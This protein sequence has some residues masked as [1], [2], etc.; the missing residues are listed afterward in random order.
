[1][2][3]VASRIAAVTLALA[4]APRAARAEVV[5]LEE[6]EA[7]AVQNRASVASAGARVAG[8]EARIALAKVPYY[9]TVDLKTSAILAPGGRVIH[10]QDY[11][12]TQGA[13]YSSAQPYAVF[14][15]RPLG[16]KGAW[17]PNFHYDATVS[18]ASRLYDF[19]RTAASVS[20]ARADREATLA[21]VRSERTAVVLEVRAAYL[22][23]LSAHGTRA[24]LAQTASDAAALRAHTEANI[25]EGSR[26]GAELAAARFEEA[27]AA[28]DLERSESDLDTARLDLEQATGAPLASNAEPDESLLE[29]EPPPTSAPATADVAFLE[30]RRDAFAASAKAHGHPYVPVLGLG[31]DAGLRGQGATPFPVY[32]LGLTLSVPIFDGGL[33]SANA[34]LATAQ[35]NDFAAQA[36]EAQNKSQVQAQ[37]SRSLLE[38]SGRRVELA[39]ALVAAADEQVKHAEDQ[40]ALGSATFDTVVQARMQAEHAR[41]EVLGAKLDHAHA[42]LDLSSASER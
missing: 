32:D 29:R 28:L 40:Y 10:V 3:C 14:G 4:F 15:S 39:Q 16:D 27:R 37:R 7:R 19:G 38:R 17:Y 18:V 31:L 13:P 25:A 20:A 26:P 1:M 6:L 5:K 24:I 36:R 23:W 33:E 21:G 9:P 12:E 2:P 22:G 34:S 11:A 30:R 8:S 42:V 41:L 35:A